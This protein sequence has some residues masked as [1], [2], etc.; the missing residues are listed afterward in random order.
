MRKLIASSGEWFKSKFRKHLIP[1]IVALLVVFFVIAPLLVITIRENLYEFRDNDPDRGAAILKQDVFGDSAT[2]IVYLKG[3]GQ[4]WSQ[5]WEPS[6]SL[7]FYNISQGSDLIP[8]DFFM[9]LEQA[10]KTEKF[11]SDENINRFRYLPQKK[12]SRNPDALPVGFVKDSYKGKD[13]VG[14]SCAACHTAQLNYMGT[15]IRIDGGPA[16][17]DME[18]FINE[19]AEAL[20]ATATNAAV[21][22]RFV[23]NVIA[24]GNYSSEQDVLADLSTYTAC[25]RVYA[26]IN[27][28]QAKI[29]FEKAPA[30][31]I[32]VKYGYARLD[33]FGRIYNRVLEHILTDDELRTQLLLAFKGTDLD[34]ATAKLDSILK[35]DQHDHIVARLINALSTDPSTAPFAQK[36]LG[37]IFNSPNAPVSYPFLWDIPQHDYVQWNGIASNAGLGPVGRNAGEVMGVFGTLDWTKKDG[38]S[39]AS[40]IEGQGFKTHVSYESSVR[41]HNLRRIEER[42]KTLLSPQWPEDLLPP[43]KEARVESGRKLFADNCVVCHAEIKRDDEN[44]RVVAH[45]TRLDAVGT[46]SKMADN[47]VNYGGPSGFLRNEY[48]PT[49][50]PGTSVSGFGRCQRFRPTPLD[51]VIDSSNGVWWMAHIHTPGNW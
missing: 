5:G 18:S 38:Y 37:Q 25:I 11:R 35:S 9:V 49:V 44:R 2:K 15:G 39:P 30:K 19:L 1:K 29:E 17:A 45:M 43:L 12:T 24:L 23:K 26:Q 47:S 6:D 42:L 46:D 10:G 34:S 40:L 28:S 36:L 14:F 50:R 32:D 33:A 13:Y 51:F 4:A 20:N 16:G 7:W 21:Q 27:H 22:A 3:K 41:V 8:Y 48:A 31:A